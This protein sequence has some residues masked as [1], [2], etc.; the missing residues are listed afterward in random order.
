MIKSKVYQEDIV[1]FFSDISE[2]MEGVELHPTTKQETLLREVQILNKRLL[3]S[4]A[5][6]T[7]KTLLFSVIAIWCA[8]FLSQKLGRK[9]EVICV[10]GSWNQAQKL[11]SFINKGLEHPYI[12]ERIKGSALKTEVSFVDGSTIKSFTGSEKQVLGE[13]PDVYLLDEA[14]LLDDWLFE[15]IYSRLGPSFLG[16]CIAGTTPEPEHYFSK[17]VEY[18]QNIK[19]YPEWKR[20][21]WK[22]VDC[23]WIPLERIQEA[24]GKLTKDKFKA[25]WEGEPDFNPEGTMFKI[26]DLKHSDIRL[27]EIAFN[28]DTPSSLGIDFGYRAETVITISQEEKEIQNIVYQ[29]GESLKSKDYWFDRLKILVPEWNVTVIYADAAIPWLIKELKA[30]GLCRIEGISFKGNKARMQYNLQSLIEHHKIRML[31]SYVKLF[32]QLA[33]YTQETNENDDRVDSLM[34]AVYKS[35]DLPTE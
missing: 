15:D 22:A 2:Y 21:S 11:H 31:E 16:L 25:K 14:V 28:K 4:S 1:H 13:H 10:S 33:I 18:Y 8:V 35:A 6:G 29:E 12:K 24:Q 17:F 23:P 27:K 3:V 32:Q 7:G 20:L 9:V 30:L 5:N 19:D 26:E 34:L